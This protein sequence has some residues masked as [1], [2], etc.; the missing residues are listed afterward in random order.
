MPASRSLFYNA[1]NLLSLIPQRKEGRNPAAPGATESGTRH[2]RRGWLRTARTYFR[3]FEPSRW[4]IMIPFSAR[5]KSLR[6]NISPNSP[7]SHGVYMTFKAAGFAHGA[8]LA[9][10][11]RKSTVWTE[12]SIV[13]VRLRATPLPTRETRTSPVDRPNQISTRRRYGS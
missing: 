8:I 9:S 2:T 1:V 13:S 7:C 5:R 10:S 12:N 6:P 3:T 11:L 4:I